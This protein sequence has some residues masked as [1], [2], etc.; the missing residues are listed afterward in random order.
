MTSIPTRRVSDG[1]WMSS[2]NRPRSHFGLAPMI[3]EEPRKTR[4]LT[5]GEALPQKPIYNVTSA[6]D[7][8]LSSPLLTWFSFRAFP[9]FPW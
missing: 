4:K 9:C 5:E 2:M 8:I 7:G 6:C 1:F 3:H